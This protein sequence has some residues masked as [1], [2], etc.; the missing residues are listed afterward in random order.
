MNIAEKLK[1]AQARWQESEKQYKTTFGGEKVPEGTYLA[2]VQKVSIREAK[3]SGRLMIGREH[4]IIDGDMKGSAVFDYLQLETELGFA[5]TRRWI[6]RMGYQAPDDAVG[7]VD[8]CTDITEKAPTVKIAVKHSGDFINVDVLEVVN[9]GEETP[10]ET[11]EE[12][13]DEESTEETPKQVST[14]TAAK[15]SVAPSGKEKPRD[16][17]DRIADAQELAA[18]WGIKL[19]RSADTLPKIRKELTDY[20]F[21]R[22]ECTKSDIALLEELSLDKCIKN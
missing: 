13:E 17:D 14:K 16:D 21:P 19:P 12:A 22:K 3:S 20:E 15:K 6:E 4:V 5:F 11:S 1:E 8:I 2:R 10:E 9:E 18:A 7:I